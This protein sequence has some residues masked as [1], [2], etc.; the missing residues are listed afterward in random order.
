MFELLASICSYVHLISSVFHYEEYIDNANW[1]PSVKP[2]SS[3]IFYGTYFFKGN[4]SAL[5]YYHRM[6][7]ETAFYLVKRIHMRIS[8][9]RETVMQGTGLSAQFG[10]SS[11]NWWRG[12]TAILELT[13]VMAK[14][15][16]WIYCCKYTEADIMSY[17][18][19]SI[20]C[21]CE[22]K[23]VLHVAQRTLLV[24]GWDL[25]NT[26]KFPSTKTSSKVAKEWKKK[27]TKMQL[28]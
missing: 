1:P 11:S 20:L 16:K 10:T 7:H 12:I 27:D 2:R 14:N 26:E 28:K 22:W 18:R 4:G 15:K 3:T 17:C 9:N 25:P 13:F 21:Y 8:S 6:K 23:W 24:L 5:S 19:S